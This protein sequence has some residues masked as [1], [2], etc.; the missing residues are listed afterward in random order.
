MIYSNFH[1]KQNDTKISDGM[2][3]S[4]L[5]IN[6]RTHG[7]EYAGAHNPLYLFRNNE[8]IVFKGDR[9]SIG[10]KNNIIRK[11]TKHTFQLEPNDTVFL[12]TDGYVDQY[13]GVNH[14]KYKFKRF[15][16]LL[17][18]IHLQDIDSQKRELEQALINWK[19]KENQIDDITVLGFKVEN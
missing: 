6:N 13:G 8:L 12:F 9:I 17:M 7:C 2:D 11:I 1:K 5:L 3:I 18:K 14:E 10:D 16:D 15:R 19:G 4:Y